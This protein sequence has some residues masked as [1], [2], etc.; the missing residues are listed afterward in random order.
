[1][2]R[3]RNPQLKPVYP[4]HQPTLEYKGYVELEIPKDAVVFYPLVD[5]LYET[6]G[7]ENIRLRDQDHTIILFIRAGEKPLTTNGFFAADILPF[8]IKGDIY[9]EEGNLIFRSSYRKTSLELPIDLLESM[10]ELAEQEGISMS[11]WVEQKLSSIL[12]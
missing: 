11:K 6:W 2:K 3:M 8:L 1:M 7:M 4:I 5:Y 10:T 12:K 9:N